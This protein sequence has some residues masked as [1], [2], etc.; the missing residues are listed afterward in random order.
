MKTALI[1]F[2]FLLL[3][4]CS[5]LKIYYDY[6]KE[7]NFSQLKTYRW[8]ESDAE[9]DALKEA[10]L[11][12]KKLV[13]ATDSL[14][15]T[16]G[17][18]LVSG[19]SSETD[20]IIV[21]FGIVKSDTSVVTT[22]DTPYYG[23][24]PSYGRVPHHTYNY[25]WYNPWY[26]PTHVG[27]GVGTSPQTTTSVQV[28]QEG[29]VI[30]DIVNAQTNELVWRGSAEKTISQYRKNTKKQQAIIQKIISKIFANFPPDTVK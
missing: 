26:A 28:H 16:K 5:S 20:F 27:I 14:L 10:E 18:Q 24:Y 30:F 19:P 2:L 12:K 6:D 25:G 9:H 8:G 3:T 7:E 17:F 4:S 22:V 21:L 1:S 11:L 15:A 13:Y 23:Y 29:T